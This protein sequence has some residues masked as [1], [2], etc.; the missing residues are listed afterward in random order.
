[1]ITKHGRG[2]TGARVATFLFFTAFA[3][4]T[5]PAW[6]AGS[7]DPAFTMGVTPLY[8]FDGT[9][10][11]GGDV[12]VFRLLVNA[13]NTLRPSKNITLRLNGGY[14]HADYD[15]SGGST[16]AGGAPWDKLHTMDFSA[17][18][19][20]TALPGW[21]FTATPSVRIAREDGADWGNAFQYGGSLSASREF[22]DTLTLGLGAAVFSQLEEV[23]VTP[24]LLVTWRISEDL[25]LA[26]PLRSGPTGPA[27]LELTY[28][29]GNGW[30]LAAG[31]SYRSE[32][33]RLKNSGSYADGVG[34]VSSIPAWLRLSHR[35][36][37]TFSLDLYGGVALGGNV[38]V[39]DRDGRRLASDDY[40]PAPFMAVTVAARF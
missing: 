19:S 15:F 20:C 10:D 17:G 27:G 4:C 26:N 35:M 31:A 1:M 23:T 40:D 21:R 12:S 7:A 8:Q 3:I 29:L 36:G 16:F 24:L 18:L 30:D 22:G 2:T 38:R 13:G 11:S 28:R 14:S 6:A 39:E 33:F 5:T 37:G 34:E 25:T 32:R 9:L